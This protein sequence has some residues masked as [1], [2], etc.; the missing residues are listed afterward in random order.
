MRLP[1]S[2]RAVASLPVPEPVPLGG[3]VVHP[4]SVAIVKILTLAAR[5]PV[6]V[7]ESR[8]ARGSRG[9]RAAIRLRPW[10]VH[11]QVSKF[12]AKLGMSWLPI[13]L[14]PKVS[15]RTFSLLAGRFMRLR[16]GR[17]PCRDVRRLFNLKSRPRLSS[18]LADCRSARP[19]VVD[20]GHGSAIR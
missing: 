19:V 14:S 20:P 4:S 11:D 10:T 12:R 9:T 8:G 1:G 5:V 7:A 6:A 18:H 3:N 2:G 16:S 13:S 17:R 15:F